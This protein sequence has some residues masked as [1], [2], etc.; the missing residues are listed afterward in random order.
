MNKSNALSAKV[1]S[2]LYLRLMRIFYECMQ[3]PAFINASQ[4]QQIDA[5]GLNPVAPPQK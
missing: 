4:E 3:L 2:S 1:D 5:E